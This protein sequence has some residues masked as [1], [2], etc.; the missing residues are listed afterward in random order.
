MYGVAAIQPW[1]WVEHVGWVVFEDFFLIISIVQS[2]NEMKAIAANRARLETVNTQIEQEVTIRT[3]EL[4]KTG[5]SW[6]RRARRRWRLRRR[7]RNFC[8]ACRTRFALR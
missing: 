4:R 5:A 2:L 1:R 3:A 6:L 7:S 8:R